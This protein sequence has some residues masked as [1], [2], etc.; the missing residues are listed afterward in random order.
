MIKPRSSRSKRSSRSSRLAGP[1]RNP[2]VAR[3]KLGKECQA[4]LSCEPSKPF[5]MFQRSTCYNCS[6]VGLVDGCADWSVNYRTKLAFCSARERLSKEALK[7]YG[8]EN[9]G[10]RTLLG[11]RQSLRLACH[12]DIG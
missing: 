9:H 2:F 3:T 4:S 5:K 7:L 6:S 12:A 10:N 1:S 11:Q 8:R